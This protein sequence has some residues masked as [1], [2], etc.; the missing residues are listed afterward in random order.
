MELGY[1][2]DCTNQ[3]PETECLNCYAVGE[4]VE[5]GKCCE[6]SRPAL[7]FGPQFLKTAKDR[8][9]NGERGDWYGVPLGELERRFS[10][11]LASCE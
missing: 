1:S 10:H 6:T 11:E 2:P 4:E 3:F 7:I 8:L 9:K 5:K